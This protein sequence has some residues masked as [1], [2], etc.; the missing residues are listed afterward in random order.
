VVLDWIHAFAFAVVAVF[1]I[2][3]YA[4]Q[5]YEVPTGS[6]EHTVA[7]GDRVFFDKF[8]FG[9]ELLPGFAKLPGFASPRRNDIIVF[10]NPAYVSK[11]PLFNVVSRIIY[12]MTFSAVNIDKDE[13]GRPRN[14]YLLKRA[15]GVGGDIVITDRSTGDLVIRP[16]GVPREAAVAGYYD[17][18]DAHP[19]R[20][21]SDAEFDRI[22]A[23]ARGSI[24]FSE[25]GLPRDAFGDSDATTLAS[26]S[27]GGLARLSD[28][29][30]YWQMQALHAAY[31][32]V[33][34]YR[35]GFA[36]STLGIYVPIGSILPIGD[37]R[38]DSQDGRFFG[39]I[40]AK[41][42]LG[43]PIFRYWPFARMG[44]VR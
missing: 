25:L 40:E 13:A 44:V 20:L 6:M 33:D 18:D 8:S 15:V 37:N 7:I 28:T 14:Q 2:N 17:T 11:G 19:Q 31:P 29:Y 26:V 22:K 23:A 41:A 3:Q 10:E 4:L 21:I 34:R 43:K 24:A 38:D 32:Q 36:R 35:S 5:A 12:M 27:I 42:V 1:F 16:L 30:A 39:P 9:P